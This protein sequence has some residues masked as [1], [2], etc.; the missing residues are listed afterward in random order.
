M[1]AVLEER[2]L[3]RTVEQL[4]ETVSASRISCWLQCRL[5]F[6]FRYLSGIQKPKS[7]ALV[8]GSAVHLVLKYWN[9]SRWSGKSPSL[10]E[11]HDRF[12][13]AWLEEQKTPVK[14]EVGQ[15][16][17]QKKTGWRLFETYQREYPIPSDE[18]PEAVEVKAEI[19]LRSKGL[20][21]LIG[22]I[23]LVRPGH[24]I[25]DYKTIGQTPDPEKVR[26]TTEVQTS[27]Y[28]LLYRD[29]TGNQETAIE[30]HHLVK[31]KSPK[32]VV[33]PVGSMTA[34]QETRLYRVME[35]YV[36][37]LQREDFVP[38]PSMQCASCEFFNECR[39]WS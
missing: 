28:S 12:S 37:G 30:L 35:S 20:P 2:P 8:V 24:R 15:E 4:L 33:V 27:T 22:V 11:F 13:D 39:G 14:W 36:E 5:R 16:E 32:L 7:A 6:Y 31:T 3:S 10:K 1:S 29:A 19:D 34:N 9:Q 17:E 23:D 21:K 26:H 38:S 18:K 25:I